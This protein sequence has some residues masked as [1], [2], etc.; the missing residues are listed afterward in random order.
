MNDIVRAASLCLRFSSH[1][2]HKQKFSLS[3]QKVIGGVWGLVEY[4]EPILEH[5]KKSRW[6]HAKG[7]R[8]LAVYTEQY[9]TNREKYVKK[10]TQLVWMIAMADKSSI[11]WTWSDGYF[12]AFSW[13]QHSMSQ[14]NSNGNLNSLASV[15]FYHC[16]RQS[17][18]SRHFLGHFQ[19]LLW[20]VLSGS[21]HQCCPPS[22]CI[23]MWLF[24]WGSKRFL[25]Q[26]LWITLQR[27]GA[28]CVCDSL[29]YWVSELYHD[30]QPTHDTNIP[31]AAYS[32]KLHR[33]TRARVWHTLCLHRVQ[34]RR[35]EQLISSREMSYSIGS[36]LQTIFLH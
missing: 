20:M 19:S 27:T 11:S 14:G 33:A 30:S 29:W 36:S 23:L 21:G 24:G 10:V 2:S 26:K 18:I 3:V 12:Q 5:V 25:V 16:F 4:R 8:H 22:F 1:C 31:R 7:R 35:I 17:I 15:R 13:Q 6:Y 28:H 9:N 32:P 34:S